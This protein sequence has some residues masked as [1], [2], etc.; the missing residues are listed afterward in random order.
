M[1]LSKGFGL[2]YLTSYK[3]SSSEHKLP[4][5][6]LGD[7]SKDG[8]RTSGGRMGTLPHPQHPCWHKPTQGNPAHNDMCRAQPGCKLL[9]FKL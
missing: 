5:V 9:K 1:F 6:C 8:N 2:K 7:R 4:E 3:I